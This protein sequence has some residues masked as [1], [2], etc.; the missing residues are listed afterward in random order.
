MDQRATDTDPLWA[1][2]MV[3][4]CADREMLEHPATET[5]PVLIATA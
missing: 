1:A 4:R 3:E 5:I 2:T